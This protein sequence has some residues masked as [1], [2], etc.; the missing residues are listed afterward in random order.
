M[1]STRAYRNALPVADAIAEIRRCSGTQF[2]PDI[3]PAFLSCQ[4]R[5]VIP[6]DVSLPEGFEEA[7]PSEYRQQPG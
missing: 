2:D 4:S 6:E 5:I 7:I 3:V 1:T